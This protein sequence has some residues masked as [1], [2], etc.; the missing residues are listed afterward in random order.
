MKKKI[1]NCLYGLLI[2][3]L[4]LPGTGTAQNTDSLWKVFNNEKF[5]DTSRLKAIDNMAWSYNSNN[6]D[7]TV[8]LAGLQL[9]LALA[10]G[11]K[12]F[13]ARAYRNIGVAYTN[14]GDYPKAIDN[15]LK[16]AKI[17]EE[18]G[19]KKGMSNCFCSLGIVYYNQANYPKAL[20]YHM[21]DM[22]IREEFGDKEGLANSYNNIGIVYF[23]QADYPRA[24]EYCLKGLKISEELNDG[25]AMNT[26]SNI[27]VIYYNLSNYPK[28]I[29]YYTKD[30]RNNERNGDKKAIADCYCNLGVVYDAQGDYGTAIEYQQKALKIKE[31]IGD[32]KGIGMCYMNI[33]NIYE[34]EKYNEKAL[35]YYLRSLNVFR[36][37]DD[38]RS[39]SYC[40]LA[41]GGLYNKLND[42]GQ[43]IRYTDSALQL[44]GGIKDINCERLAYPNLATA[45][46]KMGNY[47]LAYE[48]H[49]K[50]KALT[51]SIFNA[52]NSKL[53]GDMKTNFEVEKK[54]G[55]LKAEQEKKDILAEA[56][57][58]RQAL[59]LYLGSFVLLL[60]IIFSVFMYR[61][62]RI[63]QKQKVI[64]EQQK[65]QV[66]EKNK[67]ITDSITY[68]K[69]L[70]EAILPPLDY[71][72][73]HLPDSFVLYKPKDIVAGDFYWAEQINDLFFIAAADSTGHG[74]PGA[75][76][77]V[78]CSNALNRT[79]K[80]F[81]LTET[82]KI[83]DKTR[84]LVL[85]TFSKSGSYVR[86]GMDI[87]L[88]CIDK[89]NKKVEWSGA[90][91]PLWYIEDGEFR[92]IK[93]DKQPIGKTE[94]ASAFTSHM[95]EYREGT[96]F[97]LLTDGFADQFGGSQGKKFKYGQLKEI[98]L[99]NAALTMQQQMALLDTYFE[100]WRGPLEQIDDVTIIGI[101]L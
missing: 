35:E 31:Q 24:L 26:Y 91:N 98:I 16:A 17:N 3:I 88:L 52:E 2:C 21:K 34:H 94:N 99:S 4:C 12:K 15:L 65:H 58:K 100:N 27:G 50:F 101:R 6:P 84:E 33:G 70:Q 86:D 9:K 49:V 44:C 10:K 22:K 95:I 69:G 30:L 81:G 54:E 92:Q 5:A 76:V 62:F 53:V 28:A 71:I 47:K 61:R 25:N 64:I 23:D 59:I 57:K 51:D 40:Y 42:Y 73:R 55:E 78:V 41:L 38:A 18:M 63:S 77:S 29:E 39:V 97:Y 75:M 37:M 67:E 85:E 56:G 82:G 89:K 68:A 32:Q 7:T 14:K 46:S 93:A 66:E 45:Y 36:R 11:Q 87:S 1:T 20:E 48:S 19:N 43:A 80:E 83:L 74:V 96:S 79:V 60:V 8:M 13:E 72:A 90:N